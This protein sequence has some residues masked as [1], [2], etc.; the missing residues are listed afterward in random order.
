[1]LLGRVAGRRHGREVIPDQLFPSRIIQAER[2][3]ELARTNAKLVLSERRRGQ[4]RGG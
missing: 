3:L 2:R 1:V 4:G